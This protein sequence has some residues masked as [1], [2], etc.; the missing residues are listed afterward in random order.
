MEVPADKVGQLSITYTLIGEVTDD[1]K[2]SYGNTVIT[3]KEAE[4]AWKGTLERYS[5]Q[6]LVKTTKTGKR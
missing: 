2:F 3:E 6:L 1:G 5:R 4:E